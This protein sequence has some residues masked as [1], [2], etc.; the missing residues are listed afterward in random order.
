[1][2]TKKPKKAPREKLKSEALVMPA[3][4]GIEAHLED[5]FLQLQQSDAEGN[6]DNLMLS[7]AELLAIIDK[8][9]AWAHE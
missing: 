5:G 4:W 2:K 8:F 1:M 3:A 7:R 9:A 6:V